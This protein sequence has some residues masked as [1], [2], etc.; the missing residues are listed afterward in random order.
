M[1][2]CSPIYFSTWSVNQS[3]AIWVSVNACTHSRIPGIHVPKKPTFVV[4]GKSYHHKMQLYF[5]KCKL[6]KIFCAETTR[7]ILKWEASNVKISIAFHA[8][9]SHIVT[10]I[11]ECFFLCKKSHL[12]YYIC[13]VWNDSKLIPSSAISSPESLVPARWIE[14]TVWLHLL[15]FLVE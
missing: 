6:R 11:V 12:I 15:M 4:K 9:F 5:N 3:H 8:V 7:I 14:S 1:C 13:K 2:A 10:K